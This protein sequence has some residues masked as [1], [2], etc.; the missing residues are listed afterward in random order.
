MKDV[1]AS[2]V[3]ALCVFAGNAVGDPPRQVIS[4]DGEW[5]I[6]EG[7]MEQV[8]ARF[9]HRVPV[10][11][12]VDLAKPAFR[13]VGTTNSGKLRAAFWY[14]R[15]FKVAGAVPD[16]A[17]L[18][19]HK[20]AYGSRAFLN[21]K[22]VGE[23]LP[24]FT[25][26]YFDVRLALRGP[27]AKNELTIRVGAFR[28]AVPPTIPAGWDFE[29]QRYIP[30]IFD[31][32]ELI[33]SGTPHLVRVQCASEITNQT[34][35]VQ[36]VVGHRGARTFRPLRGTVREVNSGRL[37]GTRQSELL[38]FE[39]DD[40]RTVEMR[41]PIRDCRLWSPED[42]F[43]Y[44]LEMDLGT[45]AQRTRFGM[46]E[47]HFD[48]ASGRAV[49]NG[50]VRFL[51]GSNVTLYRFF[52]DAQRGDRPW[53]EDWVRRLHRRF[54]EMHWEALRYCIG[55]PPE[56]WYRIADEEGF[57]IQDEF[58]LWHLSGQRLAETW[59]GQLT[60][61]ELTREYTEWVQER[62]NHPCVVIWDAQNETVT[63]ETGK[64]IQAVRGLDLSGRPWDNGWSAPQAPGD[65][66][67]SHPYL[68]QNPRFKLSGLATV[69]GVPRGNVFPN[70]NTNAIVIN[71]FGWL[72]LNRDGT[73]TTLTRAVYTNLLGADATPAQR[74]HLYARYLAAKT[75]FWRAH[76]ACA[77]VLHFCGLGYSRP[78][79]QTSD[80]WLD[81][82]QL[83]YEPEF[84]R[85]VRDAFAPVGLMLDE[86]A[87]DLPPG[88]S[89]E[90]AVV[91][92]NDRYEKWKGAV[93]LRLL[94]ASR[95]LE[96]MTLPC[97]VAAL[98][99]A[100]LSFAW[101]VPGEPGHYQLE[102]ALLQPGA[103]PVRSLRDF[104]VLT[105]GQE[106]ARDGP[107]FP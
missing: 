79:G 107:V 30:G 100:R 48:P 104:R 26:G 44:E 41:I 18:K 57:L 15:T 46:R 4:L 90:T 2:F 45:D 70:R 29:K 86:W 96:K 6:A 47:F 102:A 88:Q 89:R 28:D 67:E 14:R 98:G 71:E 54:K 73:P 87:E 49:L 5:E 43:L 91:V 83:T 92:I 75:E 58:P 1:T 72:W 65:C 81:L 37:V 60:S 74:R 97:E 17:L 94:R 12:L 9:E 62:W 33:L 55:F 42:P 25:P 61:S 19:I 35:R 8:P 103:A 38:V 85:Y 64:A 77:G 40:Q 16:V 23:H 22:L 82:E 34:V 68:F 78:D 69:S 39:H 36:A 76:R 31:S 3:L 95:V 59:P 7:A 24:S 20:A 10:P 27:G 50:R 52:E 32:V 106:A 63:D 101:T 93:D 105:A 51:R 56:L 13:E 21:G 66:F 53:R 11:G 80:H 84:Y 99:D